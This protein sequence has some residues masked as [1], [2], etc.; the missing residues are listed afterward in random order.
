MTKHLFLLDV[1]GVG[2]DFYQAVADVVAPEQLNL[3]IWDFTA[4]LSPAA[5]QR[6]LDATAQPSNPTPAPRQPSISC[7]ASATSS[8]SRLP[9][10]H[11][12]TWTHDRKLW[13]AKYFD[14]NVDEIMSTSR[15]EL[16][17]GDFLLD[18]KYDN[19]DKWLL[20]W[21]RVYDDGHQRGLLW[22]NQPHHEQHEL[23]VSV[24]SRYGYMTS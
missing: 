7:A 1:D 21:D 14:F 22:A 4:K 3:D 8:L 15:K 2:A 5:K 24:G 11:T 18:D 13:L 9:L 23:G 19:V 17:I 12:P 10:K 6:Y 16:I 20:M